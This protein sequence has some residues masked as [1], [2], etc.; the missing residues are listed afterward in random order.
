MFI[1]VSWSFQGSLLS[2]CVKNTGL[3]QSNL[4]D[5][6]QM[7][8]TRKIQ[9]RSVWLIFLM[10]VMLFQQKVNSRHENIDTMIAIISDI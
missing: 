6:L 2:H 5:C 10:F 4:D 7:I 1:F 3:K 8:E 9:N